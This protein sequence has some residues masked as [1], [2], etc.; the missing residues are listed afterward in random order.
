[1]YFLNPQYAAYLI[2]ESN[3][4]VPNPE[5]LLSIFSEKI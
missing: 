4:F 2:W 1:M 5:M 3:R